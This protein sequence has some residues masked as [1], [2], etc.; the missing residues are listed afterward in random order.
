[1]DSKKAGSRERPT[2]ELKPHALCTKCAYRKKS[3]VYTDYTTDATMR[4]QIHGFKYIKKAKQPAPKKGKGVDLTTVS[5]QY[6]SNYK[7][8]QIMGQNTKSR[9]PKVKNPKIF[10]IPKWAETYFRKSKPKWY[11]ARG[12]VAWFGRKTT[13]EQRAIKSRRQQIVEQMRTP[14]P[15]WENKAEGPYVAA[16]HITLQNELEKMAELADTLDVLQK[17][18][19]LNWNYREQVDFTNIGR[20]F[21][22]DMTKFYAPYYVPK[23][24]KVYNAITIIKSGKVQESKIPKLAAATVTAKPKIV[25]RLPPV[26]AYTK[27]VEIQSVNPPAPTVTPVEASPICRPCPKHYCFPRGDGTTFHLMGC[28][29]YDGPF[30]QVPPSESDSSEH[31]TVCEVV[32]EEPTPLF[33]FFGSVDSDSDDSDDESI[34]DESELRSKHKLKLAKVFRQGPKTKGQKR[35]RAAER[36]FSKATLAKW[37]DKAGPST[38]DSS[39]VVDRMCDPCLN[40]NKSMCVHDRSCK[41]GPWA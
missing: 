19:Y 9:I 15:K 12:Y 27:V 34:F 13:E 18:H 2:I 7:A 8:R 14:A 20:N 5:D 22:A 1:M 36:E 37:T 21:E 40:R 25:V 26:Q 24:K 41:N 4:C 38:W 17:G 16:P 39:D 29:D 33:N 10:T 11:E 28:P 30:R 35:Y 3:G 31:S 23:F 6:I 32:T